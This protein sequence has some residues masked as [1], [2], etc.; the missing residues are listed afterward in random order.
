[1]PRRPDGYYRP[2]DLSFDE[3]ALTRGQVRFCGNNT[4]REEAHYYGETICLTDGT[5]SDAR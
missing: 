5:P 4:G 2:E 3:Q 1:M